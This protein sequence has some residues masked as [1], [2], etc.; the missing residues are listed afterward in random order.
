MHKNTILA[1][2][3]G[4][5]SPTVAGVSESAELLEIH[6]DAQAALA[7][8]GGDDALACAMRGGGILA[9][10]IEHRGDLWPVEI[11][12]RLAQA[13]EQ[14]EASLGSPQHEAG[15]FGGHGLSW[16]KGPEVGGLETA[17]SNGPAY[18]P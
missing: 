13:I 5:R 18:F 3:K 2:E 15:K 12:Q 7:L 16:A 4:V 17:H 9:H 14:V 10:E 1:W 6:Q 8:A 11:L